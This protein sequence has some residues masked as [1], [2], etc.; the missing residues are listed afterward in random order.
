MG[1]RALS[2]APE[3]TDMAHRRTEGVRV[4]SP[5]I[6]LLDALRAGDDSGV[7]AVCGDNTVVSAEN[8][9]SRSALKTGK[10]SVA[11]GSPGGM[12]WCSRTGLT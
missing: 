10:S 9:R 8:M 3:E 12:F 1:E 11:T 4:E 6:R 7:L 5:A 2:P